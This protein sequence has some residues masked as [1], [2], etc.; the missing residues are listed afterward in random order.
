MI[1]WLIAHIAPY[2]IGLMA[3]LGVYWR[4]KHNGKVEAH[5]DTLEASMKATQ[6]RQEIEDAIDQDADLVSRARAAGV[7]RHTEH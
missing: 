4:G 1:A 2:L 3:V 5:R 6:T 7:V